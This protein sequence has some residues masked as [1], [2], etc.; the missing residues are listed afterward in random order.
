MTT[1]LRDLSIIWILLHCCIMFMFLYESRFSKRITN[2]ATCIFMI[3]LTAI[4]LANVIL[5]GIEYAGQFI[6][7]CCVLPSL[8]FFCVMAKNRDSRFLFTF[9]VVDTIILEILFATNLLDNALGLGNYTVMFISRLIIIPIIEFI[10]V[11]YIRQPYRMLQRHTKKGWGV[12]SLMAV[13]FYIILLVVTYYPCIILD[14]PEYIPHLILIL[15]LVPVMYITVLNILWKQLKL[16]MANEENR[17]LNM[18]IKMVNERLENSAKTES[19]IKILHH[20]VRHRMILLNN[21]LMNNDI[22]S[23]V[24]FIKD[25]IA[26]TDASSF[27]N[28]C[29]NN[30]VNAVLSYYEG[31]ASSNHIVFNSNIKLSEKIKISE[32]DFAV[33]LSNGLEN[34]INAINKFKSC[35]DKEVIIKA[36]VDYGI[37]YLEIKNPFDGKI[38]FDN[39]LPKVI[40]E[41]HGYGTK[42]MAA[43]VNKNNGIYSFAADKGFFVFRCAI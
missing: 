1:I 13:L 20:D 29:K 12:F 9:C 41:N 14:R 42:S 38:D 39:G 32:T 8:L 4:N 16:F 22:E 2:I 11:K 25:I 10:I 40:D 28:Y 18:Q 34:A 37:L 33:I 6:F 26:E 17:M 24:K 5:F 30:S 19:S 43:I 7:F 15:I 35:D 23:A 3:P 21:Y 27:K 31:I 36:F